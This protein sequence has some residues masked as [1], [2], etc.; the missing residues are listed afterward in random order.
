MRIS[1]ASYLTQVALLAL[2]IASVSAVRR[3]YVFNS[4]SGASA[5]AHVKGEVSDKVVTRELDE[6][7]GTAV[8]V[9][10]WCPIVGGNVFVYPTNVGE[11]MGENIHD[12][13]SVHP[14]YREQGRTLAGNLRQ[15]IER[16]KDPIRILSAR[17]KLLGIQFWLSMRMNEIHEDDDRYMAVRSLFK[18]EHPELLHGRNYH[19]AAIYAPKKGY[20]YAWDYS[21][22]EVRDHFVALFKEW[23]QY[24]IDGIELDF[25][26]QACPF[27]PGKE[28]QGSPLLTDFVAKVKAA[29]DARAKNLGRELRLAVRVPPSLERCR[30]AGIDARTW[31][32][33]G[34]VDVV[35]PMDAGYLD[36][37][38][39]L[40]EFVSLAK[41]RGTAVLGGI[42]P[43]VRGYPQSNQQRFAALSNFLYQGADGV[44]VFNYDCHRAQASAA[45]FGGVLTGY[46][47]EEKEFL[48]HALDP[49]VLRDHDKHYLIS[50]ATNRLFVREGGDRPLQRRLRGGELQRFEMTVGDDLAQANA[51]GRLSSSRL[52]VKLKECEPKPDEVNLQVNGVAITRERIRLESEGNVV[53]LTVDAPPIRQGKNTLAL[54][55]KE[56][57]DQRAVIASI[58]LK[59]DYQSKADG[60]AG[61]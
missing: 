24:D 8:T 48:R 26:R 43:K 16:G 11:R 27:P 4:D 59:V 57:S 49:S 20:S 40:S 53:A 58:D 30:E 9:F 2:S 56:G 44:Y 37:E 28:K 29:V 12:W 35:I 25:M 19:P 21:H 31:I 18:E 51:E 55:L 47:A 52:V 42:E 5:F 15:L 23:L 1:I 7:A 6:L 13:D 17:A 14:Y 34:L 38:P 41:P 22:A 61:K 10:S 36:P 50:Q 39:K 45:S 60:P 3:L 33:R 54:G 32:E 46:T